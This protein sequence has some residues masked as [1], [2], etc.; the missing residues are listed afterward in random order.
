MLPPLKIVKAGL[1]RTTEALAAQLASPQT[2]TPT[3]DWSEVEWQLATAVA[4]AHGVS[5]LLCNTS[6]WE[7]PR[8]RLFLQQQREHTARRYERIA[9]LLE[10]IDSEARAAGLAIVPMKGSAL[11]ALGIYLP[12]ERPMADIDLLVRGRDAEAAMAVLEEL[13]YVA[14]YDTWKH[15]VFKPASGKLASGLGEHRD[16]PI[17]I[18]LHTHVQERLPVATVDISRC[19]FPVAAV[20]G[21]NPYPLTSA[22]MSHL[23]LHT[24]GNIRGR[25]V[26]LL[27]LNDIARLAK[28]MTGSDWNSLWD[29][30]GAES[31]WWALP[32]LY[33]TARYYRNCV[34]E[35]V[36][37][38][39]ARDCP[40]VLRM[41]SR[42]QTL[43]AAS[44]SALWTPALPGIEWSRSVGEAARYVRNRFIPGHEAI[45]ERAAQMRTQEWMQGHAQY[46]SRRA[47]MLLARLMGPIPRMDTLDALRR[48]F[49]VRG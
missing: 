33:L 49:E 35:P 5:A 16:N 12:G 2:G 44:C 20:P 45:K 8:W 36:L 7:N 37:S 26:R 21:L 27:H 1:R 10:R 22:L 15:R 32:A 17:T 41:V 46:R 14:S 25:S 43:T 34:P 18:E 29:L 48:A 47:N 3:P 9:A 24:G 40:A 30:H 13:G 38:R 23:L 28:R 6:T 19:I 39:L 4:A 42:N 11:H 31:P